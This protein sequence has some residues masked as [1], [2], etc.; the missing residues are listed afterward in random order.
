[1][2]STKL[3]KITKQKSFFPERMMIDFYEKT[4]LTL[5]ADNPRKKYPQSHTK[6]VKPLNQN[7]VLTKKHEEPLVKISAKSLKATQVFF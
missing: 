4:F 7:S 6:T 5:E 3:K 1:M 2:M